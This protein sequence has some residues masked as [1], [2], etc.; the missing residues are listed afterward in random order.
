MTDQALYDSKVQQMAVRFASN[1]SD[2]AT[3]TAALITLDAAILYLAARHGTRSAAMELYRRADAW[4]CTPEG[5]G[6]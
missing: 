4:A 5:T 2:E 1:G 6:K 3:D